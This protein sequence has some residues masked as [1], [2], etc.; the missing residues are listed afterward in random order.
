MYPSA[1]NTWGDHIR[2]KRLDLKLFQKEITEQFGVTTSTV[3]NWEI[4]RTLPDMSHLPKIIAF[5]GYTPDIARPQTLGERIVAARKQAGISQK[6][7]AQRIGVDPM[8]LGRWERD[9]TEPSEN[10]FEKLNRFLAQI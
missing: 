2:T 10:M 4:N 1:L 7:A 6:K 8:T 9:E 3:T 5:L